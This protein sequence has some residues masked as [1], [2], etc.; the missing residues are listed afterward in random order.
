MKNNI[1]YKTNTLRYIFE[2]TSTGLENNI[3]RLKKLID[4]YNGRS[5]EEKDAIGENPSD[6]IGK[7]FWDKTEEI[8][9]EIQ[10][11]QQSEE[12]KKYAE[13]HKD[14]ISKAMYDIKEITSQYQDT[15]NASTIKPV[16]DTITTESLPATQES[17]EQTTT[18]TE[19]QK[20]ESAATGTSEKKPEETYT[21]DYTGVSIVDFLDQS[22]KPSDFESRKKLAQSLGIQNYTGTASQNTEMLNKLRG[23]K[24]YSDGI[25]VQ[26][27]ELAKPYTTPKEG[28]G[29]TI[30]Y[31]QMEYPAYIDMGGGKYRLAKQ[32]ELDNPNM[33]LYIPNP[34]KGQQ[35]YG[36]PNFVK[37]RREGGAI[38][39]QSQF[40]GALGSASNLFGDIGNTLAKPFRK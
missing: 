25:E 31:G 17:P 7:S 4:V 12:S 9:A 15:Y 37:V 2:Q 38:R 33:Q 8:I 40:G 19:E 16:L 22:G 32:E 28:K 10:K 27:A 26:K 21:K 29:P 30:R 36:K 35:E 14:E 6:G 18:P 11:D 1:I 3:N 34:K 5:E 23:G 39:R 13:E 20:P 24:Q